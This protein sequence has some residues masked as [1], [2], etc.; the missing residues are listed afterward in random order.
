MFVPGGVAEI[1]DEVISVISFNL[2]INALSKR[3]YKT[4]HTLIKLYFLNIIIMFHFTSIPVE[5]YVYN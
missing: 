1:L 2:A 5:I 4:I 3:I